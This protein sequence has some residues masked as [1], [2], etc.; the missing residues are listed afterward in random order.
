MSR[1]KRD[2]I[3]G[4]ERD[5]IKGTLCSHGID[6]ELEERGGDVRGAREGKSPAM[7][8]GGPVHGMVSVDGKG[9]LEQKEMGGVRLPRGGA[10]IVRGVVGTLGVV[11]SV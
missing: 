10:E 5:W 3:E 4:K 1:S 8:F 11:I 9:T 2:W 7:I 6:D